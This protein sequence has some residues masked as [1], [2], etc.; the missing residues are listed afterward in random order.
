[1]FVGVW[2]TNWPLVLLPT[3]AWYSAERL[4]SHLRR[5]EIGNTKKHFLALLLNALPGLV[6]LSLGIYAFTT[7]RHAEVDS[8]LCVMVFVVPNIIFSIGLCRAALLWFRKQQLIRQILRETYEADDAI[9]ELAARLAITVRI[10]PTEYL[11]CMTV[12]VV[13]PKVIL[14]SGAVGHLAPSELEAV[15]L[16]EQVHVRRKDTLWAG[17][18]KLIADCAFPR[19]TK[20]E[21]VARRTR[22]ISADQEASREIDRFVLASVLIKFAR[23]TPMDS[24]SFAE[25]FASP[26]TI[27][28]RVEYLLSNSTQ[29]PFATAIERQQMVHPLEIKIA[30]ACMLVCYPYLI[31]IL[32]VVWLHC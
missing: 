7:L 14:S 19:T 5:T 17:V 27:S 9:S 28:E 32:A 26:S 29:P 30:L 15:L 23:H 2:S 8:T 6:F 16:H 22:E 31:R 20:A 24:F 21:D 10:L 11:A 18:S 4:S 1:M 25:S 3:L 13:R 12:G